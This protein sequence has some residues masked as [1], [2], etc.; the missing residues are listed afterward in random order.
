MQHTDTSS[1]E[2]RPAAVPPVLAALRRHTAPLHDQLDRRLA[3]MD[4][5]VTRDRCRAV[6]LG[7]H[8]FYLPLEPLLERHLGPLGGRRK[9]PLLQ[10]DL[11]ALGLFDPQIA[12]APV[13]AALPALE[14]PAQALGA[15][16]VLEGATL[17]GQVIGRHLRRHL[18]LSP[19]SGAAF[20][21]GYGESTGTMWRLFVADL[22]AAAPTEAD[23]ADVVAGARATFLAIER[24][25]EVCGLLL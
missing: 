17:G 24:W 4:P 12:E 20:F 16:Y 8:G 15:Q 1:S 2:P 3:L 5:A 11:R 22:A 25:L 13:C 9:L 19:T 10:T 23:Q 14:R 6:L 18:S 21:G 7:M